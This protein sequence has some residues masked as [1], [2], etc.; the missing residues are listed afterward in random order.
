[1]KSSFIYL[2]MNTEKKTAKKFPTDLPIFSWV[3]IY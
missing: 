2:K 3:G 1:M